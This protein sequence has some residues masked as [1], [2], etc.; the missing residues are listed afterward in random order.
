[1]YPLV[2]V[3]PFEYFYVSSIGF[4]FIIEMYMCIDWSFFS[5]L[6]V[7]KY[8]ILTR[9]KKRGYDHLNSTCSMASYCINTFSAYTNYSFSKNYLFTFHDQIRKKYIYLHTHKYTRTPDPICFRTMFLSMKLIDD[10][11]DRYR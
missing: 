8:I 5:I 2:H 10:D 3:A 6:I 1:M 11:E 9:S 4:Y 7:Y